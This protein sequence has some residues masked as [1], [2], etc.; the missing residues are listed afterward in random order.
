[1]MNFCHRSYGKYEK[2]SG[3]AEEKI[4]EGFFNPG[5]ST[6]KTKNPPLSILSGGLLVEHIGVE[7]M[8]S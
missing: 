2:I 3:G 1:M 7:P 6:I 8:T 5:R 4:R